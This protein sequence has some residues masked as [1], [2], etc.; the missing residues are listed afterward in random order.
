MIHFDVWSEFEFKDKIT[1]ICWWWTGLAISR[2]QDKYT[3]PA[4]NEKLST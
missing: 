2:K 1:L 3:G 4:Y